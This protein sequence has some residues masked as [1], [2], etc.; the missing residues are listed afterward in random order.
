MFC[1]KIVVSFE[2][3]ISEDVK[4]KIY[5]ILFSQITNW[6][7]CKKSRN[8]NN[9]KKTLKKC[10][11][12]RRKYETKDGID[13]TVLEIKFNITKFSPDGDVDA[14]INCFNNKKDGFA[15]VCRFG[16]HYEVAYSEIVSTYILSAFHAFIVLSNSTLH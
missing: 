16:D 2:L 14:I 15:P 11:R 1:D 7:F 5:D 6:K 12:K 4:V 9:G 3:V 13:E 10:Q 8:E